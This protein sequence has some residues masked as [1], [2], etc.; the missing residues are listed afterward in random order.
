METKNKIAV[1]IVTVAVGALGLWLMSTCK[2]LERA[3][4]KT[5]ELRIST[6]AINQSI[7]ALKKGETYLTKC[8]VCKKEISS[9]ALKCPHCGDPR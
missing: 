4:K 7:D 8:P 1:L 5:D 3:D 2:R 6:E 9:A